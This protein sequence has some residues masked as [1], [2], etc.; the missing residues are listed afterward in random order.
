[1][2]SRN[3]DA[4]LKM[5]TD[6]EAMPL[7]QA[8]FQALGGVFELVESTNDL[9]LFKRGIDNIL[10]LGAAIPEQFRHILIRKSPK[11]TKGFK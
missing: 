1:M 7:G 2:V 6:F 10:S 4:A 9:E 8:K 3:R 5:L 11:T